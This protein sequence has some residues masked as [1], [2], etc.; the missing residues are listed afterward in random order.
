MRVKKPNPNTYISVRK[1]FLEQ[2]NGTNKTPYGRVKQCR[3]HK[4]MNATKWINDGTS[5]SA[6]GVVEIR[7]MDDEIV[8]ILT[9]YCVGFDCVRSLFMKSYWAAARARFTTTF[10][11]NPFGHK[12]NV[13]N[14]LWFKRSLEK[15]KS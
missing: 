6:A 13:W 10:V 3:E 5:T 9:S 15:L 14:R 4:R 11:N 7:Q 2:S 1:T 8:S 12:F